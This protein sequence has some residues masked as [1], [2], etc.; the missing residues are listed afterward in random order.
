MSSAPPG[1]AC[2][3]DHAEHCITCGD[4]G[5]PMT[6]VVAD[7]G[8]GLAACVGAEGSGGEVDVTLVGPVAPGSRVLVHAGVAIAALDGTPT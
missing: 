5:V 3:V 6:V 2:V 7:A 8:D 4:E 1:P